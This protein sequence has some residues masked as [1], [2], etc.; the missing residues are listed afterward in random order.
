MSQV[1][2]RG[3]AVKAVGIAGGRILAAGDNH[4]RS[5]AR[6]EGGPTATIQ[7]VRARASDEQADLAG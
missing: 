2:A 7:L 5:G 4:V 3:T 6:T 1:R